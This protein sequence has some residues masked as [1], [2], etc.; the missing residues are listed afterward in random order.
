[1]RGDHE[2]MD[3][4]TRTEFE[5]A[6]K[7]VVTKEDL[8]EAS[9][10]SKNAIVAAV[11]A[12]I[13]DAKSDIFDG[14]DRRL[15]KAWIDDGATAARRITEAKLEIMSVNKK[16][17]ADAIAPVMSRI[18]DMDVRL[19]KGQADLNRR[20]DGVAVGVTKLV[21]NMEGLNQSVSERLNQQDE[22]LNRAGL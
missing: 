2:D 8:A 7:N 5:D 15:S 11:S 20:L 1:M 18:E 17:I 14:V 16:N 10:D 4:I 21:E 6:M 12:S 13:A 3:V 9:A 19:T 22:R